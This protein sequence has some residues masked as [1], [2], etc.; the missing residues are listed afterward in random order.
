MRKFID[1]LIL[2]WDIFWHTRE[3]KDKIVYK[4]QKRNIYLHVDPEEGLLKVFVSGLLF[5]MPL[6]VNVNTKEEA[7]HLLDEVDDMNLENAYTEDLEDMLEYYEGEANYEKCAEIRDILNN[8][9]NHEQT[10]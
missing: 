9:N 8:R 4:N 2:K 10:N 5:R 3:L 7:A 1:K 6:N